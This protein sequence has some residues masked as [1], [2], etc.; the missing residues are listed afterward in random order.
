MW[1]ALVWRADFA[2]PLVDTL[3]DVA[4]RTVPPAN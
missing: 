2:S 3:V 1:F 4:R